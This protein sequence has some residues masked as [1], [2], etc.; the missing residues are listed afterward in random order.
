MLVVFTLKAEAED[1]P[2]LLCLQAGERGREERREGGKEGGREGGR[3]GG[4]E[5][6][7]EGG[8]EGWAEGRK[9][10]NMTSHNIKPIKI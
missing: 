4:K 10:T 2:R 8:R 7:R 1:Q 9:K 3:E 5:G 6:G